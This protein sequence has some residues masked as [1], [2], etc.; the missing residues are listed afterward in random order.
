MN[1]RWIKICGFSFMLFSLCPFYHGANAQTPSIIN[2]DQHFIFR[3]VKATDD[4]NWVNA[5]TL[6]DNLMT[7]DILNHINPSSAPTVFKRIPLTQHQFEQKYAPSVFVARAGTGTAIG[8][9]FLIAPNLVLTNK[10]VLANN[11]NCMKFSILLNSQPER[12][13]CKK[14]EYCDPSLDFCVIRMNPLSNGKEI[15]SVVQPLKL[16]ASIPSGDAMA[17]L[18]GDAYGLGIQSASY[19]GILTDGTYL[20]HCAAAF[21]GNSGSAIFDPTG[22]V[23]GIH[24]AR[25]KSIAGITFSCPPDRS[26]G[27]AVTSA[28]ILSALQLSN[29]QAYQDVIG[30]N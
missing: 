24:Y 1:Q 10:H 4:P 26:L 18:I 2:S 22:E 12:V 30:S 3:D 11:S 23:I 16:S 21:E 14:V 19:A 9:A 25:E 29:P 13:S 20:V 27:L 5:G 6:L 8:T 7:T 17:I 15:G 28:K